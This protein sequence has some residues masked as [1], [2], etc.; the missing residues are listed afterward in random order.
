[1]TLVYQAYGRP[2]I[3][4][5]S[6]FSILSFLRWG[7]KEKI[8]VYT[9]QE[10][11]LSEFFKGVSSVEIVPLSAEQI[12]LWRGQIDFVHRVKIEVL[13][14]ASRRT[15]DSLLYLDGD[16][17]FTKDPK[18]MM[19]LVHPGQC[20]MHVMESR[21]DQAK[22]PLTKKIAKFCRGQ[23]FHPKRGIVSIPLSTEMW[24][25]G[26]I[27][28]HESRTN[29]LERILDLTDAAYTLYQKHVIEQ[30]AVSYFLQSTGKVLPAEPWVLHYWQAKDIWQQR[31]D[32]FLNQY[33][34]A[35]A[36]MEMINGFD[37][38]PPPAPVKKSWLQK[39]FS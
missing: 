22:D 10:A 31:I 16:T 38:T 39:M 18:E 9:D 4:R 23:S 5:Q 32:A 37:F 19:G 34:T 36:A 3:I 17:V 7:M 11:Q 26:V 20:L 33:Q 8:L 2:E 1:M 35:T 21:L 29:L 15:R 24:N 25:A 14:D 27:G 13:I 30:L 12:Q 28:I 6:Q